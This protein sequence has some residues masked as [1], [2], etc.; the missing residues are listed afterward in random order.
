M[1]TVESIL[2]L[3]PEDAGRLMT[4]EEFDAAEI[5]DGAEGWR[6]ELI[7]GVLV[8]SPI[9]KRPSRGMAG[10]LIHWLEAY[11]DTRGLSEDEFTVLFEEEIRLPNDTQRRCDVAIWIGLGRPAEDDAPTITVEFVSKRKADI[12]RDYVE[13]R[14]QYLDVNVR[15]Y[16]I[17]HRHQRRMIALRRRGRR[18]VE[19]LV[20][21]GDVYTTP[22]LP[23]FD[24]NIAK[25]FRRASALGEED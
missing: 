17:I 10:R 11:A 24:L 12:K 22:L 5:A 20:E 6:Y 25:L 21:A 14:Q 13:M 9:P 2:E 8:V 3:V 15:E 4:P 19:Y 1:S 18:W 16:W 23:G 7:R